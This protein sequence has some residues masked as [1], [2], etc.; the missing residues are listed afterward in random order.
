MAKYTLVSGVI[1]KIEQAMSRLNIRSVDKKFTP[2]VAAK[3]QARF[4][5]TPVVTAA[6]ETVWFKATLQDSIW[7]RRGLREETRVQRALADYE[8]RY[9]PIFDSPAYIAAEEARGFLWL[10]RKYW[11]GF[12][13]GDMGQQYGATNKFLDAVPAERM[14]RVLGDVRAMTTFMRRRIKLDVHNLGWYLMDF[15]YYRPHFFRPLLRHSL[16]PGWRPADVDRMEN[17]FTSHRNFFRRQATVFAHGDMYPNNIMVRAGHRAVLFDWELTHLNLPTFDSVMVY[18]HAWRQP[19]WQSAFR[20]TTWR[21]IGRPKTTLVAWNLAMLSLATRLTAFCFIRLTNSQPERFPRLPASDRPLLR[22]L[23][24]K[25]LAHLQ[26]AYR[27]F[28]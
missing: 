10:M 14:A 9:H 24:Q 7:L 28:L 25:N 6:G 11:Q 12:F 20:A 4:Y 2:A 26:A 27:S 8:D 23:Y 17:I 16:N 18:L 15:H 21:L 19:R 5:M 1:K 13:A 3:R 22:R